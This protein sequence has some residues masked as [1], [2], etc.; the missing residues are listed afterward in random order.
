MLTIKSYYLETMCS[1]QRSDSPAGS[2]ISVGS[3]SPPPHRGDDYFQPLKRLRLDT[4][5]DTAAKARTERLK[6]FSIADILGKKDNPN[7][8]SDEVRS[9]NLIVRPWDAVRG[10]IPVR[11]AFFPP[12]LLEYEQH[13]AALD[14]HR[15]LQAQLLR[16]MSVE[17]TIP[18]S[19]SGS[20]GT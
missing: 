4:A 12:A 5:T 2:E 15:Q 13:L 20:G 18:A 8:E 14:Y 19:E 1:S 10:P 9:L 6:S 16:Q 3:P 11:P 17:M 7:N